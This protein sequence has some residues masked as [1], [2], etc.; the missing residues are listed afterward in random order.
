MSAKS[1]DMWQP[2]AGTRT[3]PTLQ[4]LL[5]LVLLVRHNTS[6][7]TTLRMTNR[8][9]LCLEINY[10]S[11]TNMDNAFQ[12]PTCRLLQHLEQLRQA[13]R[14]TS[15]LLAKN[16]LNKVATL[17]PKMATLNFKVATLN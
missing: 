10:H 13:L 14:P 5:V 1:S 9:L 15:P 12:V 3:L 4:Q 8:S 11:T 17:P 16:T 6:V 2:T 7:W